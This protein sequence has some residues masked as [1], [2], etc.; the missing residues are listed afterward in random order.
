MEFSQCPNCKQY[1]FSKVEEESLGYFFK[2]GFFFIIGAFIFP[3]L[4]QGGAEYHGG[5]ADTP[6]MFFILIVLGII[7][8]VFGIIRVVQ[9][10]LFPS[11]TTKFLCCKCLYEMEYK[12]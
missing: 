6:M 2:I 3:F 9:R 10:T 11:K 7:M 5:Q 8:I 1:S 4:V 12:K